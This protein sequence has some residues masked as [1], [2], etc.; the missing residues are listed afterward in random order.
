MRWASVCVKAGCLLSP[1]QSYPGETTSGSNVI[2]SNDRT[3]HLGYCTGF[4]TMP[5]SVD[6]P[7]SSCHCSGFQVL[8]HVE[9]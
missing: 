9:K 3:I 5:I 4:V 7:V 1:T 6:S 8:P 2:Y